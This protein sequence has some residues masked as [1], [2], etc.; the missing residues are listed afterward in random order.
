MRKKVVPAQMRKMRM[1]KRKKEKRKSL[2]RKR[3]RS[4]S[5]WPCGISII[6]ILEDARARNWN[7]I[8]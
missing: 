4:P 5:Q 2:K 6:V 3:S 8:G 1:P 7:D